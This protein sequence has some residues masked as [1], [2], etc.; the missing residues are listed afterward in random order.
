MFNIF[1]RKKVSLEYSL[2]KMKKV[3]GNSKEQIKRPSKVDAGVPFENMALKQFGGTCGDIE[4]TNP[5]S[6]DLAQ[7]L[8]DMVAAEATIL[9]DENDKSGQTFLQACHNTSNSADWS[10]TSGYTVEYRDGSAD[11]HYQVLGVPF[12]ILSQIFI[13]Y[14]NQDAAWL[15]GLEFHKL[16]C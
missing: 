4:I 13:A 5:T 6:E 3:V 16:A 11:E 15:D 9:S 1:K 2:E 12:N 14:A 8:G 10:N 7:V